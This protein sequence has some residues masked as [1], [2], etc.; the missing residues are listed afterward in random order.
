MR[1]MQKHVRRSRMSKIRGQWRLGRRRRRRLEIN[2]CY[3]EY[4][5]ELGPEDGS[6]QIWISSPT[7]KQTQA[8]KSATSMTM[9]C[10]I[11][12][13][14]QWRYAVRSSCVYG[15]WNRK[16]WILFKDKPCTGFMH[17]GVW[18]TRQRLLHRRLLWYVSAVHDFTRRYGYR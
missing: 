9:W 6:W 7:S 11:L 16:V 10:K 4:V 3:F 15:V 18:G 17:A 2:T 14:Q 5:S 13:G 12:R 8:L 1:L